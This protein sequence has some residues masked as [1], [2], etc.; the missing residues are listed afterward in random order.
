MQAALRLI[1][2][3]AGFYAHMEQ[4]LITC[5]FIHQSSDRFL[6]VTEWLC[7]LGD[8]HMVYKAKNTLIGHKMMKYET[9]ISGYQYHVEY[10]LKLVLGE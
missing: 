7:R 3:G 6:A 9:S 5:F 1:A 8:S 4:N 2:G 10:I